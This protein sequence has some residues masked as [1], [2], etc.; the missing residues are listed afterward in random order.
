[1]T[2]IFNRISWNSSILRTYQV[3]GIL[4]VCR[5]QKLASCYVATI[6][7][8]SAHVYCL[9]DA[10]FYSKTP[11]C[12][13]SGVQAHHWKLMMRSKRNGTGPLTPRKN[14]WP[15]NQRTV[16]TY[17]HLLYQHHADNHTSQLAT[18]QQHP[19]YDDFPTSFPPPAAHAGDNCYI[20]LSAEM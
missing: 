13:C 10:S 7:T 17:N 18:T 15:C 12:A 1:M 16:F 2:D 6:R 3:P 20:I 4:F 19:D 5:R 14:G 8:R 9:R 11:V